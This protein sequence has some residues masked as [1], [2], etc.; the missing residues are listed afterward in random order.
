MRI[1]GVDPGLRNTGLCLID[2]KGKTLYH[3]V[4][5]YT[6]RG[7]RPLEEYMGY[8]IPDFTNIVTELTPSHASVEQVVWQGRRQ[9]IAMPLSHMAGALIGI[10][11]TQPWHP[12]VFVLTPTMKGMDKC[13]RQSAGWSD[14]EYDARLLAEK[15]RRFVIAEGAADASVLKKLSAVG[16]RKITTPWNAPSLPSE[17]EKVGK[18]R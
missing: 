18:R 2:D 6:P 8:V 5:E 16:A 1:L 7:K 13:P 3:A 9:M 15:V 17:S 10:L 4:I 12:D 14:H 11:L